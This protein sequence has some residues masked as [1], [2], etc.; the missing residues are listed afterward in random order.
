MTLRV[1]VYLRVIKI[2]ELCK[3]QKTLILVSL[4]SWSEN[5]YDYECLN[6]IYNILFNSFRHSCQ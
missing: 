4:C 3:S 6:N 2:I 5:H 1:S